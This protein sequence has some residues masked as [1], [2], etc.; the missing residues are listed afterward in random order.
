MLHVIKVITHPFI[1]ICLDMEQFALVSDF[2]DTNNR[3]N[4][5]AVT[6]EKLLNYQIERNPSHQ[7]DSLEKEVNKR[8]FAKPDSLVD[9]L[10]PCPRVNSQ[11]LILDGVETEV[12]SRI[13]LKNCIE[14][15]QTFPIFT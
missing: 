1:I 2:V 3:L 6:M 8:L 14:R 7:I 11:T 5:Q 15:T 12:F 4:T 9:Q 10:L 13:V